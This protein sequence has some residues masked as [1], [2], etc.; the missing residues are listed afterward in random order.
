MPPSAFHYAPNQLHSARL[1]GPIC[2]QSLPA[3]LAAPGAA[4]QATGSGPDPDMRAARIRPLLRHL[5][6]REQSEDC[7]N[8]NVYVPLEGKLLRCHAKLR[9]ASLR[10]Y[11]M[12]INHSIC[13]AF[14]PAG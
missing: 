9:L 13:P 1:F 6:G 12:N 11:H 2:H 10:S 7:L 3:A 5:L 8:L 4:E 14:A